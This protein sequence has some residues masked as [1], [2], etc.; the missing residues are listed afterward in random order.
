MGQLTTTLRVR[1]ATSTDMVISSRHPAAK[2]MTY[3]A[4][5]RAD[6]ISLVEA[7]YGEHSP[8]VWDERVLE[9]SSV[10]GRGLGVCFQR[11]AWEGDVPRLSRVV[12]TT[13]TAVRL[14]EAA[15]AFNAANPQLR[16]ASLRLENSGKSTSQLLRTRWVSRSEAAAPV[17][18]LLA[19]AEVR[20]VIGILGVIDPRAIV[21][22]FIPTRQRVQVDP[23]TAARYRLVGVHLGAGRRLAERAGKEEAILDPSGTLLHAEGAARLARDEL[24]RRAVAIDRARTRR[25]RADVDAALTVWRGLV[26]GRWSLVERIERDGR[27][28]VIARKNPPQIRTA[29]ALTKT[30][31]RVIE[32][33]ALGPSQKYVAYTLGLS[34]AA[35]SLHV[36][37]ATLKLGIRSRSDLI[38]VVK[39]IRGSEA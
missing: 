6:L 29:L 5:M 10:L 31:Q 26:A 35:V 21:L 8:A 17:G 4:L 38:A 33:L 1:G 37:R 23:R 22:L 13:E 15:Q 2:G 9:A 32:L 34:V 24:R 39:G 30:E 12:G 11:A 25:G 36:S 20:D 3:A 28:L 16:E 19:R 27:R 14:M 7:S 18:K